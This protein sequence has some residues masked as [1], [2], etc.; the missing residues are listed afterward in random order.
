LKL[1]SAAGVL[2]LIAAIIAMIVANSP[3]ATLYDAL[4]ATTLAVQVGDLAINKPLLLWINDGLMAV[5]FFLV[6]LEIKREVMEGEL[7]S[8]DQVVLP[9][10]GALGGMLVPALIYVWLNLGDSLALDGWAIP[11]ATDIAFALALLGVFGSRVPPALKIFLLTLAIFDDL[12]AIVIIALFYSSDLSLT[13]LTIAGVALVIGI[14]M[15]RLGVTR[16]SSYILL[17]IILWVAVLKSGV[18][19]TLAGVLIAF[20][21]PMRDA[22]G[23]SP[24]RSL[25]HNLHGPVAFVVLPVFAFANAGLSLAGMAMTDLGQPITLGVTLGLFAGKP[26]G[27]LLFVGAAIALRVARLPKDVDWAQLLGIAFA[28]G[29]GFTMSLFIAGLAFEHGSGDYF[30]GDRL[31]I[32]IGSLTSAISAFVLLKIFLPKA[33]AT[34]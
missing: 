24:L 9:A 21:V 27:I 29:I 13:A 3:L 18:H 10:V 19:A 20:C 34:D 26:I 5:F 23:G 14:A 16:T 31:G 7:S 32:L 25:E 6:G 12:A 28:C 4:L 22:E 2:L 1:E 11:V 33:P 8:P 15:N 17:G 30:A